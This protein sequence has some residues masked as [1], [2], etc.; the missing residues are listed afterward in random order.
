MDH[1]E[2]FLEKEKNNPGMFKLG[3]D[4]YK[5]VDPIEHFTDMCTNKNKWTYGWIENN[6]LCSI[7]TGLGS[8][9]APGWVWLYYSHRKTNFNN[10]QDLGGDKVI[11]AM[12]Q[13]SINR[14]LHTAYI[15][16]RHT[17]PTIISDAKG[18]M[19]QR[20]ERW[21]EIIPELQMYHWVDEAIVP[22]G[23]E[24]KYSF[25]RRMTGEGILWP[26]DLRIRCGV[27]KQEHRH[28][29]I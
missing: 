6:Q 10:F 24:P 26:V 15:V 20:L 14:K 2:L 3:T 22:A 29:V 5:Y 7:S 1:L 13:E 16:V 18:R 9:Y 11:S 21:F 28:L 19:A 8:P 27:L 4:S 12:F 23:T 25:Y 17:N